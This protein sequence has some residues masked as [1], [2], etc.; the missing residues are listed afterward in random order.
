MQPTARSRAVP[1]LGESDCSTAH[2][3]P[4]RNLQG[5]DSLAAG[6][7]QRLGELRQL[8]ADKFPET[9]RKPQ[10]HMATGIQSLDAAEGGLR[11]GAVTELTS[12][13]ANGALFIDH[14]L[15]RTCENQSFAALVDAGGMFD[16]DSSA[17]A[18]LA[19]LLWVRCRDATLAVKA[20]DLLLR[21]G[22]LPLVLMDLQALTPKELGKVPA[23]TWHRFQRLVEQTSLVLVILTRQRT[24]ESAQVRITLSNRW[25]LQALRRRRSELAAGLNA[26]VTLRRSAVPPLESLTPVF[27]TA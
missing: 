19:R 3:S 20:A 5:R 4:V 22:N 10:G 27:R 25:T 9:E 26:R 17:E 12:T 8:L 1:A 15:Q 14:L 16:P 18:A 2:L 11:C 21:D 13:P 23:S 24:V 7:V 6:G